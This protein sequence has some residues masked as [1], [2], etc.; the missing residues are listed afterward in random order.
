MDTCYKGPLRPTPFDAMKVKPWQRDMA[1][2]REEL[3][4]QIQAR[5]DYQPHA[6]ATKVRIFAMGEVKYS[7]MVVE[8]L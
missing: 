4:Q 6:M 1:Q 7:F 5:V 8:V 2:L 3:S